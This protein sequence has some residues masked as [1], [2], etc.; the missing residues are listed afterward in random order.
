MYVRRKCNNAIRIKSRAKKWKRSVRHW[1]E[2]RFQGLE[3]GDVSLSEIALV[4]LLQLL[5]EIV[6]LQFAFYE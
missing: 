4:D 1:R 3:F 5:R 6:K 2:K